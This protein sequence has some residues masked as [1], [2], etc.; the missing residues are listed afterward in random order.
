[1]FLCCCCFFYFLYCLAI[2][3][4]LRLLFLIIEKN[5][6]KFYKKISDKDKRTDQIHLIDKKA[7]NYYNIKSYEKYVCRL[8]M[9]LFLI[10]W[11]IKHIHALNAWKLYIKTLLIMEVVRLYY[12]DLGL[13]FFYPHNRLTNKEK[14]TT[15]LSVIKCRIVILQIMLSVNI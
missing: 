5:N 4:L 1:M 12:L 9:F 2:L 11:M 6:H 8:K 10:T 15:I 7:C 13:L 14:K 3:F